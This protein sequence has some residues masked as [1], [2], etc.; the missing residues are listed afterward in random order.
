MQ[1]ETAARLFKCLSEPLRLRLLRLL[2]AEELNGNELCEVLDVPQ[3]TLSR[4]LAVLKDSGLVETRR[5]GTWSFFRIAESAPLR[6]PD[7]DLLGLLEGLLAEDPA[8]GRDAQRLAAVLEG[9]RQAV[10]DHFQADGAGWDNFQER[11]ADPAV[12]QAALAHLVPPGLLVVDAGCG[13]G[14]FLPELAA[15]GGRVVAVDNAPRQ[16]EKARERARRLGL[17]NVE[18]REGDLASLPLGD[19]EADALFA[20]LSLHH[21]PQPESALRD[22]H[23]VLRPGGSLVITDFMPHEESWLRDEH[24]D[25]WPGF[26]PDHVE[27]LMRRVGFEAIRRST[28]SYFRENGKDK[29]RPEPGLQLFISS[30]SKTRPTPSPSQTKGT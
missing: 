27:S 2:R 28:R 3:S 11:H 19:G 25:L 7:A 26:D 15:S 22:W 17:H 21:A 4:H 13:A 24:A 12:K 18:F 8:A 10:R 6:G 5:Q 16:L 9:R 20:Q 29:A 14:W 30:G 23:R 1:T